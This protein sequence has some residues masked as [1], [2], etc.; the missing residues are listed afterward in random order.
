MHNNVLYNSTNSLSYSN[1]LSLGYIWVVQL[2]SKILSTYQIAGFFDYQCLWKESINGLDFLHGDNHQGKLVTETTTYAWVTLSVSLAQSDWRIL[3]SS[4]S[5]E[6]F[7]IW[8]FLHG[9]SHQRMLVSETLISEFL[10]NYHVGWALPGVL[11]VQSNYRILWLTLSVEGINWYLRLFAWKYLSWRYACETTTHGWVRPGV[12][13]I[14]SDW[15]ILWW[16]L[17]LEEINWYLSFLARR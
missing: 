2:W 3:W 10:S 7:N 1:A 16:S 17:S 14:Q 11:L 8:H 12:S 9:N 15:R 5:V 6:G 13:L 4:I